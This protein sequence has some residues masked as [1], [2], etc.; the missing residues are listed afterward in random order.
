MTFEDK[1][2]A[3]YSRVNDIAITLGLY[4]IEG[5]AE[6][7]K[8]GM[9]L[10]AEVSQPAGM[11]AAP[12]LFGLADITA[13]WL[14]MYNVDEGVFPLAVSSTVNVVAN[15]KTGDAI[16][17]ARIVRAGKSIIVTDTE[18][19]SS[20]SGTLLGKFITTYSVPRPRE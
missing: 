15:A 1:W 13:T 16:A 19:H 14:V 4:P 7:V 18:V 9:P 20:D 12:A 11:F 8:V 5:S 17:T 2:N 3:F 10:R 6:C